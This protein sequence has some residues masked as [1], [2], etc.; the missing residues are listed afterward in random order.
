MGYGRW[1]V[2]M[3]KIKSFTDLDVWQFAHTLVL[4][5]YK[6]TS[7]M[8]KEEKC[9]LVS[10]MKGAVVSIPAN[11]AEGFKR[12]GQNDKAHF[13]NIAQGSLEELRYYFILAND[14]GYLVDGRWKAVGGKG[15]K[16]ENQTPNIPHSVYHIPPANSLEEM[17]T[18]ID[19]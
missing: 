5:V 14:L 13:Y 11:I 8:P 2:K 17:N 15:N 18:R 12:K 10:Q 7:T 1:D 3:Q 16:E 19:K 4:D 6:F 9:G